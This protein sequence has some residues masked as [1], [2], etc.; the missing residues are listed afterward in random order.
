MKKTF[1]KSTLPTRTITEVSYTSID[2][3]NFGFEREC[4]AHENNCA[5][6]KAIYLKLHKLIPRAY[7]LKDMKEK[8]AELEVYE[9]E[10]VRAFFKDWCDYKASIYG[11]KEAIKVVEKGGK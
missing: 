5:N 9:D 1:T 6:W 2:G 10:R 11:M 7:S 8:L 4:I 3:L